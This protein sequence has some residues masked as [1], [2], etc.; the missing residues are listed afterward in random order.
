ME[1]KNYNQNLSLKEKESNN[2]AQRAHPIVK[3]INTILSNKYNLGPI[4]KE[5][6]LE[7]TCVFSYN[8]AF[9]PIINKSLEESYPDLI[10]NNSYEKLS[11]LKK[12]NF[13]LDPLNLTNSTSNYN[14]LQLDNSVNKPKVYRLWENI[15]G[16]NSYNKSQRLLSKK[17]SRYENDDYAKYSPNYEKSYRRDNEF[18]NNL[19]GSYRN[20]RQNKF[21]KEYE[22]E[23]NGNLKIL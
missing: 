19:N 6:L 5:T 11:S 17:R 13:L 21:S 2:N 16:Q 10:L 20:S 15:D 4:E 1:T 12:R 9:K 18:I 23:R 8:S 7:K 14:L 3:I 22:M